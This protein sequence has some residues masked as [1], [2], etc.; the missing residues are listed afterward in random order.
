MKLFIP[1]LGTTFKLEKDWEFTLFTE[2]RNEALYLAAGFKE[3][4][5]RSYLYSKKERVD[6]TNGCLEAGWKMDGSWI[7]KRNVTLPVGSII[8]ID[9][10]YIRKGAADFSSI[11]FNL[12]R[13][14]VNPD[15]SSFAKNINSGRGRCRFWVKLKDA[16]QMDV[17]LM[18]DPPHITPFI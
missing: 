12:L 11:S 18:T 3:D 17:S 2:D 13:R 5:K 10:I 9:R 1:E 4:T 7:F 16:N 8:T 6:R 14:S 15:Y